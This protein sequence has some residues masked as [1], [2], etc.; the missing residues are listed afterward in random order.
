[1]TEKLRKN[2]TALKKDK[3]EEAN[4]Q[5]QNTRQKEVNQNKTKPTSRQHKKCE[6]QEKFKINFFSK[7]QRIH[8]LE[9]RL[10]KTILKN[11]NT[12]FIE[13]ERFLGN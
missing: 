7:R 3:E 2:F 10:E 5:Y 9:T 8:L 1:M 6:K 13:L 12:G 4:E 11:T